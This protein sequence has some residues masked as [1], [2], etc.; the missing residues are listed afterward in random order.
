MAFPDN[1]RAAAAPDDPEDFRMTEAEEQL[2]LA[3]A[4]ER[5]PWLESD[6]DY[7]Q[8]A[9]DTGRIVA[10]AAASTSRGNCAASLTTASSSAPSRSSAASDGAIPSAAALRRVEWIRACAYCT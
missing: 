6:D 3:N 5:L 8:P 7:E 4:D 2:S 10:F 9:V 1:G